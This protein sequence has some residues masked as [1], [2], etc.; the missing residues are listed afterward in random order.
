[1]NEWIIFLVLL[2]EI[3]VIALVVMGIRYVFA[4]GKIELSEKEWDL[5]Q[6]AVIDAVS[7]VEQ[8][9]LKIKKEGKNPLTSEEK[10]K[11]ATDLIEKALVRFGLKAYLPFIEPL[12]EAKLR[13]V[14]WKEAAAN[15]G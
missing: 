11:L 13:Q 4:K 9:A 1:M 6:R 7:Y 3:P 2:L 12:I 5:V 8:H 15:P 14:F 10:L